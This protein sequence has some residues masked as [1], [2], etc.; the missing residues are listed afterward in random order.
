MFYD[1]NENRKS[2][3]LVSIIAI[4]LASLL[5]VGS[6]IYD[7]QS[8]LTYVDALAKGSQEI[9][10]AQDN[11]NKEQKNQENHINH[12]NLLVILIKNRLLKKV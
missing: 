1:E 11:Q 6:V 8:G 12:K 2:I 10:V 3:S 9:V 4:I 5:V 7:V